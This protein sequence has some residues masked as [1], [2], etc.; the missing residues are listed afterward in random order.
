MRIGTTA[1]GASALALL[2]ACAV[3]EIPFPASEVVPGVEAKAV[4]GSDRNG[5]STVKFKVTQLVPANRLMPPQTFYVV[6]AQGTDGRTVPLGRLWIGE[7]RQGAFQSTVP[8]IE[9]RTLVTA[10]NDIVPE[11][12]TGPIVLSSDVLKPEAR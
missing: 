7:D 10:E 5:N 6:W 2:A 1:L 9:F 11:K 3:K 4:V 8:F 12:P